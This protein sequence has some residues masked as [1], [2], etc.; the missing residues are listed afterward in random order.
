[1]CR[2]DRLVSRGS[3]K[4]AAGARWLGQLFSPSPPC[5]ARPLH[6]PPLSLSLSSHLL[7]AALQSMPSATSLAIDCSHTLILPQQLP[8]QPA[9]PLAIAAR[10]SSITAVHKK[11]SVHR[12]SSSSITSI[13]SLA[14][15]ASSSSSSRGRSSH[16]R[17]ASIGGGSSGRDSS[18]GSSLC[19]GFNSLEGNTSTY[20]HDS[21]TTSQ[22][23]QRHAV[24][25]GCAASTTSPDASVCTRSVVHR[26]EAADVFLGD[27]LRKLVIRVPDSH[28]R[29]DVHVVVGDDT[30]TGGVSLS[31]QTA[32]SRTDNRK[33]CLSNRRSPASSARALDQPSS[34]IAMD[35][36]VM[37]GGEHVRITMSLSS[38]SAASASA[39]D[40]QDTT[41]HTKNTKPTKATAVLKIPRQYAHALNLDIRISHGMLSI[42]QQDD[43]F[44]FDR[45]ALTSSVGG[46][47]VKAVRANTATLFVPMGPVTAEVD[48]NAVDI[49]ASIG[50]ITAFVSPLD[51]TGSV[52][53]T[54]RIDTTLGLVSGLVRGY[55][56]LSVTTTT[57]SVQL[58]ID[59]ARAATTSVFTKVS[60]SALHV[61]RGYVGTYADTSKVSCLTASGPRVVRHD[62]KSGRVGGCEI[63]KEGTDSSIVVHAL[64]MGSTTLTFD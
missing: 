10:R 62:R 28:L 1:M 42:D 46:I 57:G 20:H 7:P 25:I 41:T 48:A 18:C 50:P 29:C 33:H 13:A 4:A 47:A 22:A 38:P 56:D 36:V 63:G 53:G 32:R 43:A 30:C 49:S 11:K 39:P 5:P 34:E 9:A 14:S 44:H 15:V 12:S 35:T 17:R 40:A 45:L 2:L 54:V 24:S 8:Q 26:G 61:A 37:N 27:G 60:D 23:M 16:V 21:H 19:D 52:P 58:T 6:L 55:S 3:I 59:P 51:A 31:L 64:K